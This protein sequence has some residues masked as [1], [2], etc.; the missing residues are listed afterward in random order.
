VSGDVGE[1]VL[2][3]VGSSKG[4]EKSGSGRLGR[5]VVGMLEERGWSSESIHLH[6]A[7]KSEKGQRELFEA[8]D[9]AN[10]VLFAA[11]LYIDSLPAPAIRAVELI[12]AQRRASDV[13]RIPRFVS[14]VN[15]GFV[16]PSQNDTCQRILQ[17]F[18][19]R[20]GFEWV[21]RVSLGGGGRIPKRVR[22]AFDILVEALDLEILVPD[23]V[24]RLTRKPSMPG[25]L[26][27]IGGN[28]GWKRLADKNGVKDQLRARPYERPRS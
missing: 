12:A 2:L 20:S 4:L 21:A 3:L 28:V 23:E 6:A 11:P 9:R 15:C 8:I 19:D 22:R 25:W 10:V 18:A 5:L 7:V 14:I 13:E 27:V 17:R 1:R 24:E 26:Y 16:E